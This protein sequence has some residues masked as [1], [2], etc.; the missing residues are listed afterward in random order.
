MKLGTLQKRSVE[1]TKDLSMVN[2][3]MPDGYFITPD[4]DGGL[5]VT[6]EETIE[7]REIPNEWSDKSSLTFEEIQKLFNFDPL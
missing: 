6:C 4:V 1:L 3:R 5:L 2:K 7:Q